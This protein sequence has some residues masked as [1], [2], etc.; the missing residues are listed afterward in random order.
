[1][2]PVILP[3]SSAWEDAADRLHERARA[4][5]DSKNDQ[6]Q[7]IGFFLFGMARRARREG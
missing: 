7:A 6:E 2:L 5:M 3:D 1:M 4:F